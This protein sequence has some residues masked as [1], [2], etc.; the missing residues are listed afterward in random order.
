M[1]SYYNDMY[2][3]EQDWEPVLLK[4][5]TSID[6]SN[7]IENE[8]FS[9]GRQLCY[10]RSKK[11]ISQAS[12]AQSLGIPLSQVIEYEKGE[13]IPTKNII[14]RINRICG[15]NLFMFV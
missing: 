13:T 6:N 1:P 12:L 15:C 14:T 11:K 8:M 3:D 2:N 5:N 10:V 4:R 9:F 7:N